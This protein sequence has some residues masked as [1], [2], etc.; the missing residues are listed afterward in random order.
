MSSS[1]NPAEYCVAVIGGGPAGLMAAE[2]ISRYGIRVDLY[3]SMPS[4]GRKFLM[5]GKSGLNLTHAEE[6]ETF[7]SR[8]GARRIDLEAM[9]RHFGPQAVREWAQGLGVETFVGSSGRVFPKEM[10]AAPLLRSWLRR[11][12]AQGVRFHM[13]HQWLGFDREECLRFATPAGEQ[14]IPYVAALLALGGGSWARLGSTGAWVPVLQDAGVEVRPLQAANCGFEVAWSDHLRTRFA[15]EAVKSV[16]LSFTGSDGVTRQQPGEF[17][18]TDYGVEGSLVYAFA[19]DVRDAI[20]RTGT[21]TLYLD[22]LPALSRERISERLAV[23]R[24][25]R[26]LA[27]HLRRQ[28]GLSGVKVA[29]LH[30]LAPKGGVNQA[31][32]LPALLKTLPITC[33]RPR[34]LDEAISSAGGIV[35]EALDKNLMLNA[36]PGV[37]CAGEMLDWEAPT[38]GYLLTACFASGYAAGQGILQWLR[39]KTSAD[40]TIP[41]Q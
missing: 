34:P 8:Y 36:R 16:S 28:L 18:V 29:L 20:H 24:G 33:N 30:E 17:V 35:F 2:I 19:A 6:M 9:L 41:K 15:G 32:Q 4:V 22:L 25:K 11:L 1:S 14:C 27:T 10:K 23:A 13:R 26:S 12:R 5:A 7:L 37:F 3:D 21:A 31:A 38:G 40:I 39:N